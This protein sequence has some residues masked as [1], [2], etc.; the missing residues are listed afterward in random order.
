MP[1]QTA[2]EDIGGGPMA[3]YRQ[4]LDA[5]VILKSTNGGF[6]TI[7]YAVASYEQTEKGLSYFFFT[8]NWMLIAMEHLLN[9]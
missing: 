8:I 7:S 9:L 1:K 5:A 2:L 4:V 6:K 3:K